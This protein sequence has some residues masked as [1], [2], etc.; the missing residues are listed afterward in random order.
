M[1]GKISKRRPA[2]RIVCLGWGIEGGRGECRVGESTKGNKM[3][4]NT[5]QHR[6]HSLYFITTLNGT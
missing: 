5:G 1:K 3:Q 6:E 4:G 2:D